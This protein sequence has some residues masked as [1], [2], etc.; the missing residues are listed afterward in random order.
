VAEADKAGAS[1]PRPALPDG[2]VL[3]V[4]GGTDPVMGQVADLCYETL[5]RP[6]GVPRQDAWNE[7]DPRSTHFAAMEGERLVGYARLVVDGEGGHVRQVAVNSDY[8]FRGVASALVSAVV[9]EARRRGLPMTYLNAREHAVSVYERAG[10]RVTSRPFRMGRTYLRHV[11]M[12]QP[13]Q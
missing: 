5:H 10:F 6:F 7:T 8:R 1:G 3:K 4:V 9:A 2:V 11:R 12:D 13:L